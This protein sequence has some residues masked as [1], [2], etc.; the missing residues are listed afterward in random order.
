MNWEACQHIEL[1]S[2]SDNKINMG[3]RTQQQAMMTNRTIQCTMNGSI[4]TNNLFN[5]ANYTIPGAR[6]EEEQMEAAFQ[7]QFKSLCI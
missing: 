6:L 1:S 7:K 3:V 5:L 4:N 2:S